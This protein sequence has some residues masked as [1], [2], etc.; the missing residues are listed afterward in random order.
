MQN[1]SFALHDAVLSPG[2]C[3]STVT[4]DSIASCNDRPPSGI[5]HCRDASYIHVRQR[6]KIVKSIHRG[7][8]CATAQWLETVSHPLMTGRCRAY[9]TAE[10]HP[11]FMCVSA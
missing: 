8:T 2:L 3:H 4:G 7:Q 1:V 6:I 5:L 9:C 11:I 10:M